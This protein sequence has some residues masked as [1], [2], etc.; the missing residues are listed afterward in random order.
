MLDTK[1]LRNDIN[2]VLASLAKRNFSFD[3]AQFQTLEAKRKQLQT[4]TETL[5][6]QR[7]QSAKAIGQAK[8]KGEDIAPLLTSVASLGEQL[9]RN[10]AEL[11]SVQNQLDEM[12]LATPNL[13]HDSVPAGLDESGNIEVS[14]WGTPRSFDFTPLDHVAIAEQRGW[15]DNEAATKI[16]AGRFSVLKGPLARLQ[17]ALTQ[18]MLDQ[19]T[20]IHDYEEVYVP[21]LVNQ[22][23]LFGTGQLPKFAKD[24]YKIE[25]DAEHDT[26]DRDLYLIPTAEVPIT[27]LVRGEIVPADQLP[28]KYV[29]HTP[30]FRSE[31]GSY[32][33]DVKGLIRQHQFEKVELVQLVHPNDSY[34]A[35]E[36]LTEHA[37]AILEALELP[38]RKVLLCAGDMGFSAAKTYDLEVWL[39]GQQAYREISSCS[40]FEDFQ[41]RRMLARFREDQDKPQ[42]LHSLNGSGLAVGRTLLALLENHQQADGKVAIPTALQ[43]YMGGLTFI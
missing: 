26:G 8:A 41:T 32:G 18:F 33:R 14:R 7:N 36:A 11:D 35:L 1:R 39:P 15:Y 43:P 37:A 42:L 21:Y 24:L 13:P 16:T 10:K 6:A 38:Y 20:Q 22:D 17:R 27:N 34:M 30:C 31:A 28:L 5:Q 9:D 23:S 2:Q 40:N 19:H 12:L 4:D 29:G 3:Y 25:K